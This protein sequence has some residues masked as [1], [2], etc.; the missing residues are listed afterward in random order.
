[1]A[2]AQAPLTLQYD[3]AGDKLMLFSHIKIGAYPG[4]DTV[5]LINFSS[6]TSEIP[7][8]PHRWTKTAK[9]N[10]DVL[11][12]AGK[13]HMVTTSSSVKSAIVGLDILLSGTDVW[14]VCNNVL[15][16]HKLPRHCRRGD[17]GTKRCSLLGCN[18]RYT[19]H[20]LG[21]CVDNSVLLTYGSYKVRVP[22]ERSMF[23]GEPHELV[24]DSP[25][26]ELSLARANLQFEYNGGAGEVHVWEKVQV[27]DD[28]MQ[29][30]TMVFL[31]VALSSW[32]GWTRDLN[33]TVSGKS[34][35]STEELWERL[36]HVAVIVG[37]C[38]WV[39]ATVKVYQ[40]FVDAKV[41][42]PENIDILLGHDVAE[43]Y[44]VWYVGI[45][46]LAA[47][48]TLYI[49]LL[50]MVSNNY[51]VPRSV[52]VRLQASAASCE[53]GPGQLCALVTV[54]WLYESVLLTSLHVATPETIGVDF[55]LAVGLAVGVCVA[56]VAGRDCQTLVLLCRYRLSQLLAIASFAALVV[57][58]TI[59]MIF[60]SI[61]GTYG[62]TH[63]VAFV[64]SATI[65]V[66]VAVCSALFHR[67][68]LT[69]CSER[70]R[71][72]AAKGLAAASLF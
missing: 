45:V 28:V 70:D 72:N 17:G 60:P 52:A 53:H 66:Q 30:V 16:L 63:D 57:H 61:A 48:G 34:D 58:V 19:P 13:P 62:N 5:A 4:V 18:L 65:T 14:G 31:A 8:L 44:C 2:I 9:N 10:T 23:L 38:V 32:L 40:F 51:K 59:F 35:V 6:L 15:Y 22:C 49:L 69:K 25:T 3:N 55:Q 42:M 29:L 67:T 47:A 56:A 39:A 24:I 27:H 64:L 41:F 71:P 43:L 36:S 50:S 12:L 1:M 20:H 54:R 26:A 46:A 21:T 11:Y 7:R 37:D 68:P 33:A